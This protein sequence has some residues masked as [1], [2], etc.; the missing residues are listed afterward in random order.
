MLT[1]EENELLTRVGPGTPAGELL[2]HYWFPVGVAG[3]LTAENPTEVVRILGETLVLFLDQEGRVGLLDDRCPHR[4]A[5][6]SYGR[7]EARGVACPYHGW[8]FDTKG[9]WRITSCLSPD[10]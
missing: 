1:K 4:G 5:S 7:V 8:L 10:I 2:R 3:E 6:L 9:N